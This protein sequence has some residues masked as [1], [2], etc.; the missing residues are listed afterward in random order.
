[1]VAIYRAIHIECGCVWEYEVVATV[2]R[3]IHIECTKECGC[4]W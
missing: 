4:V 1:M 3:A 2:Y